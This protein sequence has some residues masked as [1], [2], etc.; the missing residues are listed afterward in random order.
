MP[1]AYHWHPQ[2]PTL[3]ASG[4]WHGR[5]ERS[6]RN[7]RS[8]T[9]SCIYS[10][11]LLKQDYLENLIFLNNHFENSILDTPSANKSFDF[12][13]SFTKLSLDTCDLI[14]WTRGNIIGEGAYGK[15]FAGLNQ[16][17]GQLMAVKQLKFDVSKKE[18]LFHLEALQT[19]ICLYKK[20]SH[21]HIVGYIGMEEDKKLNILNIFLEYVPGGSIQKRWK[22]REGKHGDIFPR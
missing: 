18:N 4:P 8:R 15:V 19:E 5:T 3:A 21:K 14:K 2:K 6:T 12:E 10:T 11:G 20:M 7:D 22:Q 16:S 9:H 1:S 13:N 17:T